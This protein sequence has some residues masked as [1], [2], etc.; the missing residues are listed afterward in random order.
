MSNPNCCGSRCKHSDGEVRILRIV[1]SNVH[2]CR[3][4]YDI[5]VRW[6]RER[7]MALAVAARFDL[8][9]WESLEVKGT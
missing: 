2:L 8:P 1:Q 4:C 3:A 9:A 5:E 7:N 6:R